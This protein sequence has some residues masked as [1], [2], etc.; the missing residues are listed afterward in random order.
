MIGSYLR[1]FVP[2]N[3]QF[4][5]RIGLGQT[6]KLTEVLSRLV[7]AITSSSLREY[8][9]SNLGVRARATAGCEGSASSKNPTKLN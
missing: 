9:N 3:K 6:R 7:W 2:L 5:M 8:W 4:K 1:A